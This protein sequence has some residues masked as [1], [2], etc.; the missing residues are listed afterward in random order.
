MI[1][2]DLLEKYNLPE[3]MAAE[4]IESAISTVLSAS[5]GTT[6]LIRLGN[7]LE[8]ISLNLTGGD[9]QPAVLVDPTT[10]SRHLQRQ[11]RHRIK[12]ELEKRQAIHE[13]NLLRSLR[14]QVVKGEIR[15]VSRTG[16]VTLALETEDHFRQLTLTGTCPVRY[17][18]KKERGGLLLGEI[19]TFLVTSILPVQQ[20]GRYKVHIRLSRT[21][22]VL[23]ELLLRQTTEIQEIHCA[24][25]I[26]GAFSEIESSRFLPK[27]AIKT[28]SRELKERIIVR[29]LQTKKSA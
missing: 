27:D 10:L 1:P 4:A 24:R 14:G 29:V 23:P 6:C 2:K 19:R 9:N 5:F 25:R 7:D 3:N 26:A 12:Q 17:I 11:I 16:D 21:S 22:K 28:V 20:N 8:I 13:G 18:P 15:Q